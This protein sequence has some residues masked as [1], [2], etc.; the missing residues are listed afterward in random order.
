MQPH[1][2]WRIALFLVLGLLSACGPVLTEES[3]NPQDYFHQDPGPY[4]LYPPENYSPDRTWPVFVGIHAEGGSG[5]DCWNTWQSYADREGFVLVCP[6]L[7]EES[8]TWH[9]QSGMTAMA[10]VLNQVV[11][12]YSVQKK[13]FFAGY[14]A[15]G[16][17]VEAILIDFPQ[18]VTG[19]AILAAPYYY[20]PDSG[21]NQAPV[22]VIIG[23]S[24]DPVAVQA[25]QLYVDQLR[26]RGYTVN[27]EFPS[28]VDH[29]LTRDMIA[30]TLE[31]YRKIY[32][33]P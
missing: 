23:Q 15:G 18:I 5:L 2:T 6:S 13:F 26:Q 12:D 33:S 11:R 29:R 14:S 10:R 8:G 28:G 25:A 16:Q 17:F 22:L 4:Y 32:P 31:L 20:A 1:S 3:I 21:A 24:E 19:A 30:K 7:A 27:A 9:R